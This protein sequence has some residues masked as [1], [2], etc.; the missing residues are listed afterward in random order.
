MPIA[1]GKLKLKNLGKTMD[2][3]RLRKMGSEKLNSGKTQK[4]NDHLQR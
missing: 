4:L 2:E 1:M 3:G